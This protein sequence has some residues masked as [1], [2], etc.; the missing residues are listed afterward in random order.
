MNN[1]DWDRFGENISRIVED[2]VDSRNFAELNETIMDTIDRLV[3][4]PFSQPGRGRSY[5]DTLRQG[6]A[7]T[8]QERMEERNRIRREQM[9]KE[10]AAANEKKKYF[11]DTSSSTVIGWV[12][13]IGGYASAAIGILCIMIFEFAGILTPDAMG[14]MNVLSIFTAFFTA[15]CGAAGVIGTR[16]LRLVSRFKNYVSMLGDKKYATISELSEQSRRPV[17]KLIKDLEKMMQKRWFKQGHFDKHKTTFMATNEIY[18]QYLETERSRAAAIEE[19][20]RTGKMSRQEA[21]VKQILERGDAFIRQIHDCNNRIPGE[22]MTGKISR[23]ELLIDRIFDRVE[24]NPEN[25][26][27]LHRMMSYYL[28]T[29]VK[30]LEAYI[31]L[32]R[33]PEGM[34]NVENSK[35]EIEATLDTLNHAF[36]K[37][38]DSLFEKTAWD[39]SSDISVLNSML[40]QEGL[41]DDG[42]RTMQ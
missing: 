14:I 36:E 19:E 12:L 40:A 32:E 42:L 4:I 29:T 1:R 15:A 3:D 25:A 21:E 13:A 39:V 18:Q 38:L 10:R 28:P 2:A 23:M 31:E 26:D 34:E 37:L 20:I 35:H 24:T 17:P 33:Q 22:E 16:M 6:S 11:G 27:D 5:Q 30:L 7:K 8:N 41:K 9:E